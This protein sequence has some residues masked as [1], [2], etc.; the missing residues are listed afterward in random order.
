VSP[1]NPFSAARYRDLFAGTAVTLLSEADAAL[2]QVGNSFQ[3]QDGSGNVLNGGAAYSITAVDAG[4][5]ATVG[6]RPVHYSP[7]APGPLTA[8]S[9]LVLVEVAAS[10]VV[11]WLNVRIRPMIRIQRLGGGDDV[12]GQLIAA[13]VYTCAAP[14]EEWTATGLRRSVELTD[15]LGILDQ[16]IASGDPAGLAAYTAVAGANIL[17]LVRDLITGA[18]EQVP[19]IEPDTKTLTSALV[20]DMGT[21]RLKVVNDLL[22]AAG[23]FSLFCDG[24]GQYQ[25]KRYVTPA[26]RVPVYESIAPFEPGFQSLMDPQWRRDRDIYSVPN[27]YLAVSQGSGD[28]AALT[29]IATNTDPTSPYSFPS[30]GRWITR[31]D[32]GVEAADQDALDSIARSRL[33][34]ASSV[35]DQITL[36]HAY[37]PDLTVNSVVRFVNPDAGLDIYCYVIRTTIPLDPLVLCETTMRVVQ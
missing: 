28:T 12:S 20:W 13:G 27:R 31:V 2:V 11:D 17:G 15:K 32:T 19:A 23:Y 1:D 33:S 14:V 25:A 9:R 29:S 22:D 21:T 10:T 6:V 16:D 4:A 26:D 18:G 30:R 7:A 3:V 8:G 24:Y 34:A 5:A 37:L 35:T 36:K